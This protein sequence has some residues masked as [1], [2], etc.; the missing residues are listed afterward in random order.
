MSGL[1]RQDE[2]AVAGLVPEVETPYRR[3]TTGLQ[4]G[5]AGD[6]RR[7]RPPTPARVRPWSRR[8]LGVRPE[9]SGEGS[10]KTV[11]YDEGGWSRFV[12]P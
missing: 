5:T 4:G 1:D 10:A 12:Y 7:D 6:R 9:P 11:R 8:H 3:R 2:V